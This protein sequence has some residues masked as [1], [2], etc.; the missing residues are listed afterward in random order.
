MPNDYQIDYKIFMRYMVLGIFITVLITEDG[1]RG[2]LRP[3]KGPFG[4]PSGRPLRGQWAVGPSGAELSPPCDF[5]G[6]AGGHARLKMSNLCIY[7]G[8]HLLLALDI[9]PMP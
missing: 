2:G 4:T 9:M 8:L 3:L 7:I 5:F 6:A 1:P